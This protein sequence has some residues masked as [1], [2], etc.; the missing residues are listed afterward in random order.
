M[1]FMTLIIIATFAFQAH[2]RIPSP[3]QVQNQ[4]NQVYG[5]YSG[6]NNSWN[7]PYADPY[8]ASR[9]M[10]PSQSFGQYGQMQRQNNI[11]SMGI[12]VLDVFTSKGSFGDKIQFLLFDQVQ[13]RVHQPAQQMI[14]NAT[15]NLTLEQLYALANQQNRQQPQNQAYRQCTNCIDNQGTSWQHNQRNNHSLNE[16]FSQFGNTSSNNNA[17]GLGGVV[18]PAR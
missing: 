2:G 14:G 12:S 1:R 7:S 5:T 16:A 3:N 10:G 4:Q 15:Q 18:S 13:R 6:T 9:N 17:G 8:M 11:L